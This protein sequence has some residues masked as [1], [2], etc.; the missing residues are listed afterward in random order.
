[1]PIGGADLGRRQN[2]KSNSEDVL[3]SKKP[4]ATQ[5]SAE[6][7]APPL[8]E[9]PPLNVRPVKRK[10]S[11]LKHPARN[12]R[13]MKALQF[14]Q[15]VANLQQDQTLTSLPLVYPAGGDIIISG[16]H[17]VDAA[18]KAGIQEGWVL[19]I[20]GEVPEGRLTAIQLSHN[21]IAG[22]DDVATLGAMYDGL[23]FASKAY[24]GLTDDD[25][26]VNTIDLASLSAGSTDYEDITLTFLPEQK[27]AFL[28]FIES[29][30]SKGSKA[31]R[32]I[33]ARADFDK[34]FD[35]LIG[36]KNKLNVVN[37]SLAMT[38]LAQLANERL[39]QLIAEEEAKKKDGEGNGA[40]A[41]VADASVV[42]PPPA[43]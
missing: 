31:P 24:S 17:R 42:E 6:P 26:K 14:N 11:E 13:F 33:G 39:D 35:G 21:A 38:L 8:P 9:V 5:A 37:T 22:Q 2:A 32:F 3:G 41:A 36:V 19:E 12:A 16:N 15:L 7:Q 1:M 4:K 25:F 10:L 18:I 29:L 30:G 28:K 43:S 23:D 27:E 20:E 40:Q 34:I